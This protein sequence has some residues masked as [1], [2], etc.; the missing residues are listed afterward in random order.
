M[1]YKMVSRI[2]LSAVEV[3]TQDTT[4]RHSKY[5]SEV[6]TAV[7]FSSGVDLMKKKLAPRRKLCT[8]DSA[9]LP[10]HLAHE[11]KNKGGGGRSGGRRRRRGHRRHRSTTG[12]ARDTEVSRRQG[13][14]CVPRKSLINNLG[15]V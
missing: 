6:T 7:V 8:T 13:G 12:I 4:V 15:S 2:P 3:A 14:I 5:S 11:G 1:S 10:L 9:P